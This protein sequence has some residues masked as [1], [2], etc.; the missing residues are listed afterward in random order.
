MWTFLPNLS[1]WMW[2]ENLLHEGQR[3]H[4]HPW[5]TNQ[6]LR[7]HI[8]GLQNTLKL[9]VEPKVLREDDAN[10]VVPPV[11]VLDASNHVRTNPHNIC[12]SR[13]N[14]L[15]LTIANEESDAIVLL[16]LLGSEVA[17]PQ[18]VR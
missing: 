3:D 17:K 9:Q 12:L 11:A 14:H 13:P 2:F 7:R 8:S 15:A 6:A 18:D 5:R 1:A 4:H 10:V 16:Q